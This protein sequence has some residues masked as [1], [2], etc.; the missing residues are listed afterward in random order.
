MFKGDGTMEALMTTTVTITPTAVNGTDVDCD[1]AGADVIDG[2][3]FLN[4]D[5]TYDIAF[6]L[7]AGVGVA[8]FDQ[9]NP[10]A[11]RNAQ[12]PGQNAKPQPPCA[13]TADPSAPL[14]DSFTVRVSPTGNKGV[15]H[16]RLN[17]ADELSCDPIMIHL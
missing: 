8:A 9:S 13:V 7:Q 16:Y 3:I 17:F 1:I 11:N 2:A 6:Q 4:K 15:S 10:F 5:E 12:C 14:Y